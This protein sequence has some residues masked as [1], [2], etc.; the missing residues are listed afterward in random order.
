ILDII[1]LV[2]RAT[3]AEMRREATAGF[4][5]S[6][7]RILRLL[8]QQPRTLSE[9]AACQEVALP[10]MSRTVSVLVERGWVTRSEDPQDRRRVQLRVTDEGWA[11]FEKLR[12]RVQERLAARLSVLTAEE[13]EQVLAG[14]GILEKAFVT[15]I[16]EGL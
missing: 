2:M 13:R 10:T 4:Q 11:V 15:E 5:I 8:Q 6:H 14:L 7:Y 12:A 9:L 16:D 3:G 1:P